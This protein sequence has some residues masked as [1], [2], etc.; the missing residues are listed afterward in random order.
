MTLITMMMMRR[1]FSCPSINTI[2][3]P[4][5]LWN[6]SVSTAELLSLWEDALAAAGGGEGPQLVDGARRG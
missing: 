3:T 5:D 6:D 2:L 1:L 4:L